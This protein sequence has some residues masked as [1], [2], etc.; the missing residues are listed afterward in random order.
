MHS[1][2]TITLQPVCEC[3]K[4]IMQSKF[5]NGFETSLLS[6]DICKNIRF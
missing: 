3:D 5:S 6:S 1:I 4:R 2:L